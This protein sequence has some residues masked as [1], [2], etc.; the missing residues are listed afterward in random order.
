M[1]VNFGCDSAIF[2]AQFAPSSEMHERRNLSSHTSY[3]FLLPSQNRRKG[4][5]DFQHFS[6]DH[7]TVGDGRPGC[8]CSAPKLLGGINVIFD[9]PREFLPL[10]ESASADRLRG[11]TCHDPCQEAHKLLRDMT[12]PCSAARFAGRKKEGKKSRLGKGRPLV[13]PQSVQLVRI[14][15]NSQIGGQRITWCNGGGVFADR[16]F[17]SNEILRG[18]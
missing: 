13:A 9:A 17:P 18:K 14:R 10:S 2:Q 7:M 12:G 15:K 11:V 1:D 6:G 8:R 16:L 3:A 4:E 5:E